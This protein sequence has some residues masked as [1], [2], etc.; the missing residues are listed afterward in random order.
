MSETVRSGPERELAIAILLSHK[1]LGAED[2]RPGLFT[3][4]QP[5]GVASANVLRQPSRRFST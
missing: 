5:R 2:D 1:V 3:S 4:A